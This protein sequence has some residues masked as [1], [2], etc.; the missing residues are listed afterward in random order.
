MSVFDIRQ[1]VRFLTSTRCWKWQD[2]QQP[3]PASKCSG[4]LILQF[5]P[6]PANLLATEPLPSCCNNEMTANIATA[7]LIGSLYL[8]GGAD[9]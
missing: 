6:R 4:G 9:V 1:F 2:I 3:E 5:E 8:S 7:A